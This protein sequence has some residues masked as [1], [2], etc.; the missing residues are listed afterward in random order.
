MSGTRHPGCTSP[1]CFCGTV[2]NAKVFHPID[3]P[4]HAVISLDESEVRRAKAVEHGM[5]AAT[6]ALTR[7]LRTFIRSRRPRAMEGVELIGFSKGERAAFDQIIAWLD[8]RET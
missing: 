2:C 6:A 1:D 4:A 7:D 3:P 5:A 8:G